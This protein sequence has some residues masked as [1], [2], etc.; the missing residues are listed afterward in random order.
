MARDMNY[1]SL[2]VLW[3][4]MEPSSG[5]G[6]FIADMG[7]K[8]ISHGGFRTGITVFFC[9]LSMVTAT[10]L[11]SVMWMSVFMWWKRHQIWKS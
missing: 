10:I 2:H 3:I 6:R 4:W 7:R 1:G 9:I 11:I 5:M 8:I